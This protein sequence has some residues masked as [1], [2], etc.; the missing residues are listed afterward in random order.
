VQRLRRK[1]EHTF[2][3]SLGYRDHDQKKK[4]RKKMELEV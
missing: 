3:A 4:K 1:E 2:K